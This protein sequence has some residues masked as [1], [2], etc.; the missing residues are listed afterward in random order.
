MLEWTWC[1]WG[2]WGLLRSYM[3]EFKIQM[4]R[5]IKIHELAKELIVLD[6]VAKLG[7]GCFVQIPKV[8]WGCGKI[9][10]IAKSIEANDPQKKFVR[11]LKTKGLKENRSQGKSCS[12]CNRMLEGGFVLPRQIMFI[13]WMEC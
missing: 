8:Y 3:Q 9:I 6:G 13:P 10:K 11:C 5:I 12:Y 1:K 7:V 4:K 2:T